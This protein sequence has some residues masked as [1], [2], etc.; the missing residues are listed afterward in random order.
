MA[1]RIVSGTLALTLFALI[2]GCAGSESDR[3][4]A[5]PHP[6]LLYVDS[7]VLVQTDSVFVGWPIDVAPLADGTFL[8]ADALSHS[9]QHYGVNGEV[10]GLIGR[11]GSG[12]GEFE[13]P[14]ARLVVDG[15]SLIFVLTGPQV[16][17]IAFPSGV[18]SW[19]KPVRL[20]LAAGI[21]ASRGH[22]FVRRIDPERRTSI[23]V[24]TESVDSAMPAGPFP[25]PLGTSPVIDESHFSA[26]AI[27][28]R[29]GIDSVAFT[30]LAAD[31]LFIGPLDGSTYDSIAIP[32][33]R[34][35][36]SRPDLIRKF[37]AEP[38]TADL[39]TFKPSV[40][41]KLATLPDGNVASLTLDGELANDRFQGKFFLS[42]VDPA[43]RRACADAEVPAPI[44]PVPAAAF[45]ADTLLVLVQEVSVTTEVRTLIRK[46]QIRTDRCVWST[47]SASQ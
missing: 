41:W 29:H 37:V 38:S 19:R 8:V 32:V 22:V 1:L 45:R 7:V 36:G 4:P 16:Q 27:V 35:Q 3:M 24:V 6:E 39:D 31:F 47:E 11:Q 23:G 40:P 26:L 18:F 17:S 42:V 10:L 20:G 9:L 44:D 12:P 14:V 2:G 43:K 15:D 30:L 13:Y 33:L 28:P 5:S 25:H 21:A 34:R 46:Y